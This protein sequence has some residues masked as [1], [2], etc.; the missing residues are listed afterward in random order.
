MKTP[1]LLLILLLGVAM[2]SMAMVGTVVSDQVSVT[3]PMQ[4]M[5]SHIDHSAHP[6]T[7]Q[8]DQTAGQ[9]LQNHTN[10]MDC[11]DCPHCQM[12]HDCSPNHC[13]TGCSLHCSSGLP[14]L[15]YFAFTAHKTPLIP[16]YT[17]QTLPTL[18]TRLLR[19]PRL[20]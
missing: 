7:A 2:N 3:S 19:P 8:A 14:S 18:P 1:L 15:H 16:H 10:A 13:S 6:P 20:N 4:S 17:R 5:S 11:N 12:G 9:N